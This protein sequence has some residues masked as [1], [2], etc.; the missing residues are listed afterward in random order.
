MAMPGNC[1]ATQICKE[2]LKEPRK[3]NNRLSKKEI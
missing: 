1:R 2:I 3:K